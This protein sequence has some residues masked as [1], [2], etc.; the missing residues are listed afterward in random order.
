M[1]FS[2]GYNHDLK[3]LA[4]LEQY[5]DHI[6][7]LYFPIPKAYSGSGRNLPQK[8]N[9][10]EEIPLLIET[11][12][13]LNIKSQLLINSTCLGIN[14]YEVEF[15][16]TI[17]DYIKQLK[18][19]GLQSVVLANPVYISELRAQFA[20]IEL[21]SSING[22]VKTPEHA[23]HLK[24]LGADVVTIDRDINRNLPLIKKIKEVG[25][26]K[27]RM[28]V[29]EGCLRNCP[30]RPS[31]FNYIS[32]ADGPPQNKMIGDRFFER[33]CVKLYHKNPALFLRSSFVPP[34]G[35]QFYSSLVDYFKLA[36][37]DSATSRIEFV[38]QS[39]IAQEFSG[40]L[41]DLLVSSCMVPYYRYIDYQQMKRHHYFE[42]MLTCDDRC[43]KCDFCKNLAKKAI[44]TDPFF[45][46]ES[47]PERIGAK[48]ESLNAYRNFVKTAPRENKVSIYLNLNEILL[49][50]GR[51]GEAAEAAANAARLSPGSLQVQLALAGTYSRQKKCR[52]A[53]EVYAEALSDHPNEGELYLRMAECL[54]ELQKYD[55]AISTAKKLQELGY[56][57]SNIHFILGSCYMGLE[58]YARAIDELHQAKA[59]SATNPRIDFLLAKCY[60][61]TGAGNETVRQLKKGALKLS[62]CMDR[63]PTAGKAS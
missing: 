38:L 10:P 36:T 42:R 60:Q 2:I 63:S 43:E 61:K 25:G 31:H 55:E 48:R 12:K 18:R 7:A 40:T 13:S 33:W 11:C 5:K 34:D 58:A 9:Y 26:L 4:L 35:L 6:E 47:H 44:V 37:R 62:A 28:L 17:V 50:L 53:Y 41:T 21:E 27:I 1:K 59:L 52:Q 24:D 32:H 51:V 56:T 15:F 45:L 14:G 16:S 23:S 30:F 3:I 8:S 57:E 22:Y 46:D 29:N 54:F 19:H 39:Y 20:D 49:S